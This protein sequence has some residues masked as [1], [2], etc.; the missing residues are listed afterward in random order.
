MKHLK[1]KINNYRKTISKICL[2]QIYT[3]MVLQLINKMLTLN[4]NFLEKNVNFLNFSLKD[5][6]V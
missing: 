3:Q 5:L 6:V 2:D 1:I 4:N